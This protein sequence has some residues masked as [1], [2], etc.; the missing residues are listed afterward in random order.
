[1]TTRTF[2]NKIAKRA[3]A[4]MEG[5][6]YLTTMAKQAQKVIRGKG[7]K[8]VRR[9]DGE[10]LIVSYSADF[11]EVHDIIGIPPT[12]GIPTTL[13][14]EDGVLMVQTTDLSHAAERMKKVAAKMRGYNP[15]S[16][17]HQVWAWGKT[18]G[19]G[20]HFD[21][22]ELGE[23]DWVQLASINGKGEEINER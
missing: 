22:H 16:V 18:K 11:F 6:G 3:V 9:K 4:I 5:R 19:K 13:G 1:V 17:Y 15:K 8:I 7:G 2:G 14:V 12:S 21:R 10:P 23:T 20:Y